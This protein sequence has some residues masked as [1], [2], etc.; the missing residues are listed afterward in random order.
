MIS[1][2]LYSANMKDP[3]QETILLIPTTLENVPFTSCAMEKSPESQ[4]PFDEK[5]PCAITETAQE[6]SVGELAEVLA[7]SSEAERRLLW[8][9][10]FL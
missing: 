10:D 2:Y 4:S 1:L 3:C 6:T 8:K 9:L 7:P 5:L